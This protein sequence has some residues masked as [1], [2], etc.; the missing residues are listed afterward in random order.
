MLII[1]AID[2]RGG[3]CVRLVQGDFAR[4]TAY[5]D[6]PVR[7]AR[8]WAELGARWIHLVDLDGARAGAPQQLDLV[9]AIAAVG[10]PVE[11]GGGLRRLADL[12]AAFAAGIARAV[13]GTAAVERPALMAE[14]VERF[15]AERIVL[16]VDARGG[17]VA[18]RGWEQLS[19]VPAEQV[20]GQARASGV[21]RV[22]YTDIER[23]GTLTAPNFAAIAQMA[24]LGL[25]LI[26]SGGVARREDLE[27]LATIDGVE[28]AIVGQA[29]YTG[30]VIIRSPEDWWVQPASAVPGLGEDHGRAD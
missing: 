21:A 17:R 13:L 11:L 6:D 23:D 10:V 20:I 8:R 4:E 2:L 3:R 26:A 30:A 7:V 24:G 18:V 25:S 16:G 12:D 1:P 15:G 5:D 19:E 9:R 14:A 22:I 27:R 28:A 29:L